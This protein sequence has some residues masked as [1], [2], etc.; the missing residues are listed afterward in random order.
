MRDFMRERISIF[1]FR[2]DLRLQDNAGLAH[3]LASGHPVLP[4]FIFDST[5]L[6]AIENKQDARVTFI[7]DALAR[8]QESLEKN[9]HGLY[10]AHGTPQEIFSTLSSVYDIDAVYT[11]QDHEAY[12][13]VRDQAIARFAEEKGF[14]L[15]TYKDQVIFDGTDIRKD[16]GEPYSVFTPYYR[17]WRERLHDS[18][19]ALYQSEKK[20]SNFYRGDLPSFP[21]LQDIGF[22][23]TTI[24]FPP[25]HIPVKSI[26]EYTVHRD[27]PAIEEGTS[28][29]GVHL[30][31]GTISI[32]QL[33]AYA[34]QKN[35]TFV[36]EL[37]WREFY[38]MILQSYPQVRAN[39]AFKPVYDQIV[40]RND[41]DEFALW[42]KGKTG[43]PLVDAGMRELV[44]TGHMHNRVRMVTASF[45]T[46]NLLIDWRWG[47]D[48]FAA[49]LLDFDFA[50]NNGGWQWAAG[51]G[52]DAAPYFRVFNPELQQKKFDPKMEYIRKWIP[53]YG[54]PSYPAPMVDSKMSRERCL[55][56]YKAALSQE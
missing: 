29:L 40:W 18:D 43:Y 10:V 41:P 25:F 52:C 54:T 50:S 26:R 13:L 46:K 22:E 49:H 2:R 16:N 28:R 39:K 47:Q 55:R 3:A 23:P 4:L 53:E 7:H 51:C 38:Q 35:E 34:L 44:S 48:F 36:K 42:C 12:A 9:G 1:W 33:M 8:M 14:A 30:R 27:Y 31:F 5:I 15:H 6:D 32:R 37:V 56:V 24:P 21:S 45:L 17:R 20:E 11:N 19:L